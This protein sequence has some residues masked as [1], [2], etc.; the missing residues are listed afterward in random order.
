MREFET[1]ATRDTDDDKPDFDGFLSPLVLER[2][3]HYMQKHR[4]QADGQ[5]R[6]SDNWQKGIPVDAY[7]K[8][9]WR[10][11]FQAWKIARGYKA[12]DYT[13]GEPIDIQEALCATLFNA[14][15]WLHEILKEEGEAMTNQRCPCT[16]CHGFGLGPNY[17]ALRDGYLNEVQT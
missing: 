6:D 13:T 12:S 15:G 3:G 10:H 9:L 7:R 2:F 14:Q 1:G 8:S 11:F 4:Y 17:C 5:V 16:M